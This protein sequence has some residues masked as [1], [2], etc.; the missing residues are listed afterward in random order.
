[1]KNYTVVIKTLQPGVTP[2]QAQAAVENLLVFAQPPVTLSFSGAAQPEA[3]GAI[4]V[5]LSSDATRDFL[6]SRL[7]ELENRLPV[8]LERVEWGHPPATAS[9]AAAPSAPSAEALKLSPTIRLLRTDA[10]ADTAPQAE[11]A[12]TYYPGAW[13]NLR[14][15]LAFILQLAWVTLLILYIVTTR[16]NPQPF[17]QSEA[18]AWIT[19]ICLVGSFIVGPTYLPWRVITAFTCDLEGIEVRY[20]LNRAPRRRAWAEI[21]EMRVNPLELIL[22]SGQ[23]QVRFSAKQRAGFSEEPALIKTIITRAGLRFAGASLTHMLYKRP[24]APE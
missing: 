4:L 10:Y 6:A 21:Y 5:A 11:P 1:V 18:M 23:Q 12:R 16:V 8:R 24:D 9:A 13:S 3:G 2:A 15:L 7:R 14:G 22:L 17:L 19:Q 20:L